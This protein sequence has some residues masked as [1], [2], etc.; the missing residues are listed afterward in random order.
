MAIGDIKL[1]KLKEADIE[2]LARLADNRKIWDNVRD[3]F[4]HPYTDRDAK[5][6]IRTKIEEDPP[7]ALA[8]DHKGQLAGVIGLAR[9]HDVYRYSAEV[10]YWL[11]EEFWGKGLATEALKMMTEYGFEILPLERLYAGVFA[12][13]HASIRVLEKAGYHLESVGKMAAFKNGEFVDEHRY[14]LLKSDWDRE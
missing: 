11:G 8:I 2:E 7:M 3:Q 14:V 6:F 12:N 10:G 1:R 4:P 9:Q 13:N 5:I